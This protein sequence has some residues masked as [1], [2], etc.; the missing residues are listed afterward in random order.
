ML[1]SI[2]DLS[3]WSQ[4]NIGSFAE[5]SKALDSDQ[6]QAIPLPKSVKGHYVAEDGNT[7]GISVFKGTKHPE[8]SWKIYTVY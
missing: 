3:R 7:I 6:F 1:D 4:H 2:L 5:H 8:E